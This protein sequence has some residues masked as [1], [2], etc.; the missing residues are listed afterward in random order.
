MADPE[1]RILFRRGI[2]FTSLTMEM[3]ALGANDAAGR[4][5]NQL[6]FWPDRSSW[7]DE[8]KGFVLSRYVFHYQPLRLVVA[9]I[10]GVRRLLPL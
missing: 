3:A 8:R 7:F 10:D 6:I 4:H 2:F 5:G 1:V 9:H